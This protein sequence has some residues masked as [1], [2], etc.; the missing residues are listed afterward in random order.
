MRVISSAV[1]V[2]AVLVAVLVVL[3]LVVNG[4][5]VL[6]GVIERHRVAGEVSRVLPR[7]L[8]SAERSQDQLV[9]EVGREPRLRWI[10]QAC[11]YD[12]SYGG[13]FVVSWREVCVL[14]SVTAWQVGSEQEARDLVP[15]ADDERSA[16]DGCTLLGTAGEPGV[17]AG[18]E[19][20]Y[21]DLAGG[22]ATGGAWCVRQLGPLD[23]A[24]TLA[25][26]RSDLGNGRWLLLVAEQPLVD[27]DVGCARW[28]V[29]FCDNPWTGHAFGDAAG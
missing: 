23:D 11:R 7:I 18:P 5:S 29:L 15:T 20:T 2:V 19:A 22:T 8:P 27:E 1:R 3:H 14:R 13:W 24:R 25:G 26:E 9:E 28:S 16:Y 4:A 21:V 17:V 12:S 6:G 10:E